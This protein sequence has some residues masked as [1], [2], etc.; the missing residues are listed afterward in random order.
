[1]K[2]IPGNIAIASNTDSLILRT[3]QDPSLIGKE[4][5][6]W[7]LE[8]QFKNG[9]FVRPKLYCYEDVNSQK[10]FRKASGVVAVKL[11]SQDSV[12][13]AQGKKVLTHKDVFKLNW[14]KLKLEVINQEITLKGVNK[15]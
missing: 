7:K 4:L 15:I 1:M 2:N 14:N 12:D 3:P 8:S 13:L 6:K 5:G 9:V 10:L 11:T